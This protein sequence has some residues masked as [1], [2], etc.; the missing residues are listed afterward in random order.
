M[1]LLEACSRHKQSK[2]KGGFNGV[3]RK[4]RGVFHSVLQILLLGLAL[5]SGQCQSTNNY[6]GAVT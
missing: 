5:S 4:Q 1:A 6:L 2:Q 3:R